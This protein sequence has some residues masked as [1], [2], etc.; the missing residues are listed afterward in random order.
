MLK[1]IEGISSLISRRASSF[2]DF[3]VPPMSRY[4]HMGKIVTL[5]E[6]VTGGQIRATESLNGVLRS[7]LNEEKALD[8]DQGFMRVG[9][10]AVLELCDFL[11]SGMPMEAYLD[12]LKKFGSVPRK[13]AAMDVEAVAYDSNQQGDYEKA[14]RYVNLARRLGIIYADTSLFFDAGALVRFTAEQLG[15]WQAPGRV[16]VAV[17]Q[18]VVDHNT[19][20]TNVSCTQGA[21][22]T[23]RPDEKLTVCV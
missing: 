4:M 5:T 22:Q 19:L 2:A 15:V 9:G 6:R 1:N 7:V 11:Q 8:Y 14:A 3:N 10:S 21:V 18:E 23:V 16:G 20:H 12:A 17:P 13:L